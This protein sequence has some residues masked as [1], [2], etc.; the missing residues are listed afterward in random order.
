VEDN[1]LQHWHGEPAGRVGAARR[2]LVLVSAVVRRRRRA[3]SVVGLR[4]RT[5]SA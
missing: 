2:S 5:H 1:L 4:E 3:A